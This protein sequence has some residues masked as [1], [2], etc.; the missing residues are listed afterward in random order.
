MFFLPGECERRQTPTG[1]YVKDVSP[2]LTNLTTNCCQLDHI[3]ERKLSAEPPRSVAVGLNR[4]GV[5]AASSSHSLRSL[6]HLTRTSMVNHWQ[7]WRRGARSAGRR[8]MNP[9]RGCA[10]VAIKFSACR[11]QCKITDKLL[12]KLVP[13]G[14][15]RTPTPLPETDFESVVSGI[16]HA[17]R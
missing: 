8:Y 6:G 11:S 9:S 3:T 7:R 14:E 1:V 17:E 4:G 5:A 10:L 2:S 12:I 13:P 16:Y 15:T